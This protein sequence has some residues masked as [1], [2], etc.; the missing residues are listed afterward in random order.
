MSEFKTKKIVKSKCIGIQ[1]AQDS[2]STPP[3]HNP[4]FRIEPNQDNDDLG[5]FFLQLHYFICHCFVIHRFMLYSLFYLFNIDFI[6][7]NEK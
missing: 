1:G 5:T 7:K 6:R 2:P 3:S 4:V